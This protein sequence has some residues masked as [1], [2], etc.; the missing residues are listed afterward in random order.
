V[1]AYGIFGSAHPSTF[2]MSLCDGSARSI[3]YKI[4][5]KLHGQLGNRADGASPELP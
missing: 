5:A 2:N 3:T 1:N 4:D